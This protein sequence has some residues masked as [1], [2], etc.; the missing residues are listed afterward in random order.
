MKEMLQHPKISKDQ[1]QRKELKWYM[2]RWRSQMRKT[3]TTKD[4][5]L[6]RIARQ[7]EGW[8]DKGRFQR[9]PLD[10][11]FHTRKSKILDRRKT[12]QEKIPSS[13]SSIDS[14]PGTPLRAF[15]RDFFRNNFI[16]FSN[17]SSK[18]KKK[19]KWLNILTNKLLLGCMG[20]RCH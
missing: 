4:K 17:L 10:F 7:K 16:S 19:K 9:H 2:E 1:V 14:K 12:L 8:M 5:Y 6:Q 18:K 11:K 20:Y 3:K 13:R 15:Q